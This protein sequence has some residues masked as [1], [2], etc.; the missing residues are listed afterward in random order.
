MFVKDETR[1]LDIADFRIKDGG[2]TE[3]INAFDLS[4]VF[5][6]FFENVIGGK[7]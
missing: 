6:D 3:D 7:T 5:E 1:N 2:F 4:H